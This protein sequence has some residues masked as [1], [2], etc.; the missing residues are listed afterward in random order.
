MEYTGSAVQGF[1]RQTRHFES[2][3]C[4]CRTKEYVTK[5]SLIFNRQEDIGINFNV[6]HIFSVIPLTLVGTDSLNISST[7]CGFN[8]LT[9]E[10]RNVTFNE[11]HSHNMQ[12][13]L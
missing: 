5:A 12:F 4:N 3:E 9:R 1:I 2:G 11:V 7:F 8:S 6:R 10:L 13:Y